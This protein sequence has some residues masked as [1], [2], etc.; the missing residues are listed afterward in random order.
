MNSISSFHFIFVAAAGLGL[1]LSAC[2]PGAS[3]PPPGADAFLL[4]PGDY[5]E[6][7]TIEDLEARFGKANAR[8]EAGPDPH[9]VLFPDDPS[10]RAY[11]RFHGGEY[12]GILASISVKDPA[13]LWRGKHGV[14]VGMSLETV[15]KLNGKPFNLYGFDPAQRALVRDSWSPSMGPDDDALGA[16]DV[17]EGDRL[18]FEVEFGIGAVSGVK[19]DA[20]SLPSY[21]Q[22][23]SEDPRFGPMKIPLVVTAIS[24]S[25]SLDDEWQ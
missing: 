3:S 6:G 23:S 8:K 22:F 9:I 16:F 20:S 5:S 15:R 11:V 4:L 13:S 24:A 10:R 12:S 1:A 17:A 21:E 25:S 7:T 19:T 14:H 2:G 18:Y